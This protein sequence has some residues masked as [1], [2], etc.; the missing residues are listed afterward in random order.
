MSSQNW[1]FLQQSCNQ[2]KPKT[3]LKHLQLILQKQVLRVK[4]D[5][6]S[7][8]FLI[9]AACNCRPCSDSLIDFTN[10]IT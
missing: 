4:L 1:N 5:L 2:G 8:F 7:F 9:F 3:Q 10:I 6:M